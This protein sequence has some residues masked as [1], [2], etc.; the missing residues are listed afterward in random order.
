MK[1][2]S[3]EAHKDVLYRERKKLEGEGVVVTHVQSCFEPSGST[4]P[5]D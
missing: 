5:H 3:A 1:V 2:I 4:P